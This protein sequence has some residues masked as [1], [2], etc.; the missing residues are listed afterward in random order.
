MFPNFSLLLLLFLKLLSG[1]AEK[2]KCVYACM[3][4]K[5]MAD[6]EMVGWQHQFKRH[7]SEQTPETVQDGEAWYVHGD[8]KSQ[9]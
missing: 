5:G 3:K 6:D 1:I 2:K 4:E 8:S 7:D 9:T